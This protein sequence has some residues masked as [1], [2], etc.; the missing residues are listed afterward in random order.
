MCLEDEESVDH[1]FVHCHWVSSLWFL[2]LSLMGVCWAQPSNVK[3]VLVALRR[4]LKKSW[5]HEIWKLVRLVMW[6]CTSKETTQRIFEGRVSSI[7]NFR[8]YF[9]GTL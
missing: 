1:L 9:L 6:W 7:Q 2:V 8:L 5:V 3:D 4:R